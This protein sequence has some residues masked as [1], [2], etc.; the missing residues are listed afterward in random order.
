MIVLGPVLA[1]AV[2][3][4]VYYWRGGFDQGGAG[5]ADKDKVDPDV[6]VLMATGPLPDIVIGSAD[7]PFTIVE[8]ASMTCSHCARIP[9]GS[10]PRA[11]DQ[12]YRDRQGPLQVARVPARQSCGRGLHAGAVLW[13]RSL[14]PLGRRHVRDAGELGRA[15][16]RREDKLLQIARQAG[17]SKEQF[18]QCL[19]DKDLFGKVVKRAKSRMTSFRSIRRQ[20]SSSMASGSR[21]TT[22]SRISR[23]R[24]ARPLPRTTR[25]KP[26]PKGLP[27]Q[28]NKDPGH[29]TR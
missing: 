22:R 16:G 28:A 29:A 5:V 20:P 18:D 3:A 26:R 8:Y 9:D 2:A 13:Q 6:A 15:R 12:I 25:T 4:C 1:V 24:S 27:R 23:S 7:A 17:I 14:L 10:V 11:E 19:A 21:A